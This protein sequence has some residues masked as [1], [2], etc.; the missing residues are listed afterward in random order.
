MSSILRHHLRELKI[1][2]SKTIHIVLEQIQMSTDKGIDINQMKI[3]ALIGM[4]GIW[5]RWG[6]SE[7]RIA[8]V[9]REESELMNKLMNK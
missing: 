8:M 1:Y 9:D 6:E 2:V 3:V 7:K 4:V 5:W